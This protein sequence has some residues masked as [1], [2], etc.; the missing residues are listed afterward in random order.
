E[1]LSVEG[2]PQEADGDQGEP[3]AREVQ[4]EGVRAVDGDHVPGRTRALEGPELRNLGRRERHVPMVVDE[5]LQLPAHVVHVA[6]ARTV[7]TRGASR[8]IRPGQ[9]ASL[10]SGGNG[11]GYK[12]VEDPSELQKRVEGPRPGSNK[13]LG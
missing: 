11:S 5:Q 1:R 13:G 9:R 2:I 3:P 12:C 4:Q 8:V 10:G 6:N 7:A